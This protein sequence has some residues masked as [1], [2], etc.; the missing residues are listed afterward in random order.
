[1]VYCGKPSQACQMCKTR[2][3]KCD[4]TKP[5]CL[6]CTKSRRQC[7]GYKDAFDLVFRNE[8]E[9]TERR[10][11][12][13]NKKALT[14]KVERQDSIL[15]D[16]PSTSSHPTT[17]TSTLGTWI[18]PSS[19]KVSVEE[20]ASC[21]F[22]SNFVLMPKDGSTSGHLDF[23]LPLLKQA[24]P[25]SHI[26]HAF[27]ACAMTFLNNRRAGG[28]GYWDKALSEYSIALT[29]TNAAL[30]DK[31]SQQSDATLAAVLLLGMFENISAKQISAFNWGSH[32]DGAVQ[33][34]KARGKKQVETKVGFQLF[35]A[36]RTLM[37]VY[38]LTAFTA[39]SMGAEWWLDNT[40]FSKTA[41]VVQ[42][43][44]IKTSEIRAQAI[45]LIDSLT[46]SPENI[47]LMLE[48]IRKAQAVD[49]EVVAWQESLPED[50]HYKTVAW[51]DSVLSGDCA[52]AEV[53]PGRV[54]VYSDVWIG[55]VANSARS[56]RLILQSM[57]VRC[58]AWV[59]A[60]VDY[61]TTPEY[62]TAASVC[63]DAITDII[64]SVPYFLGWHLRRKEVSHLKTNFGSF[65]CGEEDTA[66][67]LAGYLVTWPLTCVISQDYATD[68]QR[69]WV[70]GRL[71]KIGNE[72]G[73]KYAL[74]MC[75]LQMRVPSMM[76]RRDALMRSDRPAVDGGYQG[77]EKVV[78]A[79]LAPPVSAGYTLNPQQQWEAMQ[80]MRSDKGKA[81][82]I[83]KMTKNTADDKGAQR[84]AQ[85]WLKI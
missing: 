21:L 44:M 19:P 60:P 2:R 24:G 61:R 5:T 42:R 78:E 85:R 66:K 15:H 84:A 62:A 36:V 48:V 55:T 77:L 54:D 32:I 17:D 40:T 80:K 76:I 74:A 33:L 27:N 47:E 23:V 65:P 73:V 18:M 20:K 70:M 72:L 68:A 11:K 83:E 71:R 37:S 29:R 53:F 10:A 67:G 14:Q 51:E 43:L 82:L 26:Q 39:P 28:A 75:Q 9:A 1:M 58:A 64:A 81:E 59:C 38:C 52:K 4:Y 12:K 16:A 50:W 41:V 8:T 34:V 79:R 13:A 3:I 6:Q 35:L 25:D 57:S 30:R 7:P 45:Q 49:Q 63:R 46:K 22:I 56:L 31:E 69:A